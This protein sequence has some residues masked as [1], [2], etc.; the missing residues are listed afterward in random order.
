MVDL[1]L[2]NQRPFV[3]MPRVFAL[4]LE[5]GACRGI[6]DPPALFFLQNQ[7]LFESLFFVIILFQVLL[8]DKI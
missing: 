8:K 1:K 6:I 7:Y 3:E 2:T 4:I 5:R